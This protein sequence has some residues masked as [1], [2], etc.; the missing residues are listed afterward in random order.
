[1]CFYAFSLFSSF[2]CLFIVLWAEV[3]SCVCLRGIIVIM[4]PGKGKATPF[5]HRI[6]TNLPSIETRIAVYSLRY[7]NRRKFDR[8][9]VVIY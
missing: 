5:F 7:N 4:R 2:L 8:N 3:C 1:M 9:I 6:P